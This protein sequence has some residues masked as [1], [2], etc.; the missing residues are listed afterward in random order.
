MRSLAIPVVRWLQGLPTFILHAVAAVVACQRDP[1]VLPSP[2]YPDSLALSLHVADRQ[3][4][5][6]ELVSKAFMGRSGRAL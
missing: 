6:D 4:L 1:P 5:Q 2:S 3:A